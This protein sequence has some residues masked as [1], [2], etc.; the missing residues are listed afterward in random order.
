MAYTKKLLTVEYHYDD[1]S[2]M[3]HVGEIDFG[4]TG[5]LPD[6]LEKYGEEGMQNIVVALS[7]LIYE[8]KKEYFKILSVQNAKKE[9]KKIKENSE[10]E[11]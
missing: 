4:I 8:V 11:K 5:I 10:K 7:H 2:G 1:D 3:Y 9:G 6:Y